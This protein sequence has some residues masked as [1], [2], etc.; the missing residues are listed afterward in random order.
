MPIVLQMKS[1]GLRTRN[2]H[3]GDQATPPL[4]SSGQKQEMVPSSS[5]LSVKLQVLSVLGLLWWRSW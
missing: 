2:V 3:P 5:P 1:L 4:G